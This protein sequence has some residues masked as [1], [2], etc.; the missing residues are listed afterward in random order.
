[1]G[2][3]IA[4]AA[5]RT[6]KATSQHSAPLGLCARAR[7]RMVFRKDCEMLVYRSPVYGAGC[8]AEMHS[9]STLESACHA[10]GVAAPC[11]GI[12]GNANYT[13]FQPRLHGSNN[14][15]VSRCRKIARHV[16]WHGPEC[17]R[18]APRSTFLNAV[19][20]CPL[21]DTQHHAWSERLSLQ[22]LITWLKSAQVGS[23]LSFSQIVAWAYERSPCSV[24][25][26]LGQCLN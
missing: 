7:G 4:N 1:M 25:A 12:D 17:H 26:L 15:H 3:N 5:L 21:L 24:T 16:Q 8:F 19:R 9:S 2:K 23:S 20:V 13:V 10:T 14:I 11:W 6:H 22:M 18:G